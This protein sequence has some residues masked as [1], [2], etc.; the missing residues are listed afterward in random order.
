MSIEL[1]LQDIKNLDAAGVE[2]RLADWWSGM[3]EWLQSFV[4]K[5]KSAQGVILTGLVETAAVDVA[6][7]G[8]TTASFV[9]AGKDVLAKAEAQE[10]GFSQQE[11][12]SALNL[13]A[14]AIKPAAAVPTP[15]PSLAPSDPQPA[16]PPAE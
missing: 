2:K 4:T 3:P 10:L 1:L 15:D 13:A 5:A 12:M 14:N 6:S 8:F 7:G 16:S 11:V 9:S